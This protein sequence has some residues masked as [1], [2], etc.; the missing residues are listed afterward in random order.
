MGDA[1]ANPGS[2]SVLAS[3]V[4]GQQRRRHSGKRM[5]IKGSLG[6][7]DMMD[8][9]QNFAKFFANTVNFQ[10]SQGYTPRARAFTKVLPSHHLSDFSK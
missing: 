3:S 7:P 1:E 10:E 9:D 2:F 5:S 6:Q 4:A 8:K